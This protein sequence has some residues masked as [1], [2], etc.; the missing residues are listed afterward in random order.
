MHLRGLKYFT[1]T[2]YS[3]Q[4]LY[5][6]REETRKKPVARSLG[7]SYTRV[8]NLLIHISFQKVLLQNHEQ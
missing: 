5:F 6:L 7:F 4:L 8:D 3:T 2:V 1:D